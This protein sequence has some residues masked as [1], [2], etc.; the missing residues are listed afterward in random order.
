MLLAVYYNNKRQNY[1]HKDTLEFLYRVEQRFVVWTTVSNLDE[2]L[3]A[4][5][6]LR[7]IL[8]K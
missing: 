2:N 1:M 4:F 5:S 3:G 7:K 8:S 6:K